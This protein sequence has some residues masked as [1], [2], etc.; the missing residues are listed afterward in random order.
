MK[1]IQKNLKKHKN[2]PKNNKKLTFDED[3]A[4]P[5]AVA[6]EQLG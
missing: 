6:D 5:S 2:P 3:G 1:I 4:G